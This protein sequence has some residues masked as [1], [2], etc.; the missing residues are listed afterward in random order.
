VDEEGV[1]PGDDGLPNLLFQSAIEISPDVLNG[2][3]QLFSN[4]YEGVELLDLLLAGPLKSGENAGARGG[5]L[6]EGARWSWGCES[7]CSG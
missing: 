7:K 2:A 6:D 3:Q 4:G 5:D 1:K